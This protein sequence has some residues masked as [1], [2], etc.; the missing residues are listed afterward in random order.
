MNRVRL[1]LCVLVLCGLSV[2]VAAQEERATPVVTA[3]APAEK[4]RFAGSPSAIQM[5]IEVRSAGGA[6]VYDS[7]WKD[8]NILDWLPQEGSGQPLSFGE[9]RLVMKTKNLAGQVSEKETS[10]RV[11]SSGMAV[12]GQLSASPKITLTAHDGETGQLIA[13]SGDL[14]FRFGDFLNRKDTE[15]MRLTAAGELNVNGV[16]RTKGVMFPDGTIL[17]TAGAATVGE[18]DGVMRQRPSASTVPSAPRTPNRGANLK[19]P[20]LP[21]N[22]PT[23]SAAHPTPRPNFAPDFQF[24]VT[25][26]G[27]S[28]GTTNPA[29]RL[30]V[31]GVINT[32]TEYDIGGTAFAHNFGTDNA[33]LGVS[34]GNFAMSGNDNT[35]NGFYALHYNSTGSWNTGS[36]A[37]ALNFNTTGH[38]NAA[39]GWSALFA[40]STGYDNTASG[41]QALRNNSTG[42]FNTAFGFQTLLHNNTG[43]YNMAIG[44][45][46]LYNNTGADNLA[47]GALAGY[48]LTTGN[49][50]I[51]I[52]NQGVAAEANTI[53]IG[54]PGTHNRAFITGIRDVTV[55]SDAIN[56]VIDSAGQ[57]GTAVGVPS[58]RRYKF[59]INSMDCSTD[60]LMRLRPVTFRYLAHGDNAPLQYG[61]IAEEV[62]EVYP[63]LVTRNKDGEVDTV[64][65]QFLAPMLLNEVQKQ[66]RQIE[67]Q[68]A[69]NA[70]LRDQLQRLM[71]RVDRLEAKP[72]VS[73]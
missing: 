71:Q 66:H 36:G 11:D 9:Y 52:A 47:L 68:R 34:A 21:L 35:A 48:N 60:G 65:Y 43:F 28:V 38:D 5:R 53:R 41:S 61:L 58:S 23:L 7:D 46:A 70:V 37:Y 55:G 72:A 26:V 49:H 3:A 25:D 57:L 45:Q 2:T 69:E 64:M 56:V 1:A 27:V 32:G 16:I 17:T 51:H 63:E 73:Q 59:D 12:E 15:A 18:G 14:S 40:N 62:A 13:T 24:K 6:P 10:L 29:Y 42:Y 19:P 54:T 50:N 31:T 67:E 8:G 30:D 44:H 39:S 4:I 20:I 33:F 22:A